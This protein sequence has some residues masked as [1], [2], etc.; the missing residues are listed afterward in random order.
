M[1]ATYGAGPVQKS[2]RYSILRTAIVMV[3]LPANLV[4]DQDVSDRIQR[5]RAEYATNRLV[6]GINYRIGR[7][8]TD[9]P[10]VFI[11]VKV[12]D[13]GGATPE[14]LGLAQEI[15]KDLFRL[16]GTDEIG[17][18]SYLYFVS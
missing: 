11:E 8:W 3:T 7:D 18:H 9:D 17:L 2:L 4:S 15:R 6:R 16:V 1:R 5:L 13:Q 12:A 10:A 14:L